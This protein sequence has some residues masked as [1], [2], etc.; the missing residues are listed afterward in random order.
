MTALHVSLNSVTV[1]YMFNVCLF[2]F[3]KSDSEL[4][5]TCLFKLYEK[6][7]I[8][9]LA[10]RDFKDIFRYGSC[11]NRHHKLLKD[12]FFLN[13][14]KILCIDTDSVYDNWYLHV[15]KQICEIELKVCISHSS[16]YT[17]RHEGNNT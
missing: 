16:N 4:N 12:F 6:S 11:S 7:A 5:H 3:C 15:I 10:W 8:F 13:F 17:S 14:V 2:I 9:I 1:M